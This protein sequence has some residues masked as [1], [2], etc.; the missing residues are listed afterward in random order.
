MAM[1]TGDYSGHRWGWNGE[2]CVAVCSITRTD[3]DEIARPGGQCAPKLGIYATGLYKCSIRWNAIYIIA[4][5]AIS[6]IA[7]DIFCKYTQNSPNSTWL[8]TSRLDTTRHVRRVERVGRACRAVLFQD[9][10]RWTSNSARL[11]KFCRLYA[12]TYTNPICSIK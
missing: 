2:F 6:V 10:R 3:G 11:Y 12:L 8:I 9:G 1:S 7:G 5:T 4:V